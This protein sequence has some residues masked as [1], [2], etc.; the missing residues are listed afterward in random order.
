MEI[1]EQF[2]IKY[3]LS[4][5]SSFLFLKPEFYRYLNLFYYLFP[6]SN[7]LQF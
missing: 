5:S 1:N 2:T 7:L 3:Y 4:F 6:F